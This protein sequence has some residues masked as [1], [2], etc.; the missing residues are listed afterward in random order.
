MGP[1]L[2]PSIKL[3]NPKQPYIDSQL[4]GSQ[5]QLWLGS[6]TSALSAPIVIA[7]AFSNTSKVISAKI[8]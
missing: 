4:I 6:S 1:L 8:L 3:S 5:W 2:L 7:T